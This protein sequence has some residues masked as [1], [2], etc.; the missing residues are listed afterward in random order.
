[1]FFFEN[2]QEIIIYWIFIISA[3]LEYSDQSKILGDYRL[4]VMWFAKSIRISKRSVAILLIARTNKNQILYSLLYY[5]M[6]SS[7]TYQLLLLFRNVFFEIFGY[8]PLFLKWPYRLL[9]YLIFL[10]LSLFLNINPFRIKKYIK[11]ESHFQAWSFWCD[12]H[13]SYTHKKLYCIF[14]EF[15]RISKN[16][17]K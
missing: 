4:L 6:Q 3:D 7:R 10:K 9:L 8:L 11:L 15:V 14:F 16:H 5:C 12:F 17:A 2:I 13:H 1:M